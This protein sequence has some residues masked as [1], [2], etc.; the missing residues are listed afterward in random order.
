MAAFKVDENLPIE[1]TQLLNEAGHDASSI[2]EQNMVGCSDDH[3]ASVCQIEERAIVTLD[4]DFADIRTFPPED[5]AGLIVLRPAKQDKASVLEI[6]HRMV[7]KLDEEPIVGKLWI[8]TR[9]SIR[10]RG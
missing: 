3:I 5:H 4:L 1:V 2:H 10:I 7:D 9:Q 8:V 6:F